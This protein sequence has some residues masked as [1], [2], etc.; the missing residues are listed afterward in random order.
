MLRE[1][2][3]AT[4]L[5]LAA[6]NFEGYGSSV[7]DGETLGNPNA[8]SQRGGPAA[9]K[10]PLTRSLELTALKLAYE[11]VAK[12]LK[13]FLAGPYI[14]KE[15]LGSEGDDVPAAAL[16]KHLLAHLEARNDVSLGEHRGMLELTSEIVDGLAHAALAELAVIRR[17]IDAVI[18]IPAS[19][20]S[21]CELG[22]WSQIKSIAEKML[23]LCDR[24]HEGQ[25]SYMST[26]VLTLATYHGARVHWVDYKDQES[27]QRIVSD[28]L[29]R[30]AG[31]L[32]T[33]ELVSGD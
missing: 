1:K 7:N 5:D 4:L 17:E 23:I 32:L 28:F 29:E 15:G 22:A 19:G 8:A 31:V 13:I 33:K 9:G 14:E 16:R 21:F 12:R 26:G 20:G 6:A 27:V 11:K 24:N 30:I 3:R 25:Q 2:D 10:K 18:I